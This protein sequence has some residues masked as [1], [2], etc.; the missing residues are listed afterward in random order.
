MSAL[1][2]FVRALTTWEYLTVIVALIAVVGAFVVMVS[3]RLDTQYRKDQRTLGER[4]R[5]KAIRLVNHAYETDATRRGS[6]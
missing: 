6:K 1:L 5:A 2:H 3:A 4:E